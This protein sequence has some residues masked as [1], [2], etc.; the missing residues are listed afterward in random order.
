MGEWTGLL[1]GTAVTAGV[2]VQANA[3]CPAGRAGAF[4]GRPAGFRCRSGSGCWAAAGSGAACSTASADPPARAACQ[5]PGLSACARRFRRSPPRLDSVYRI[6]HK[7]SF[8]LSYARP[9]FGS[10]RQMS[11]CWAYARDCAALGSWLVFRGG[12]FGKGATHV[13]HSR[14][15]FPPLLRLSGLAAAVTAGL[16]AASTGICRSA[17]AIRRTPSGASDASLTSWFLVV[18]IWLVSLVCGQ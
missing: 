18:A 1:R 5:P 10:R 6:A 13:R 7:F 4:T 11:A 12:I 8:Q 16:I 2:T 14:T 15:F 9:T 17:Q 3:C